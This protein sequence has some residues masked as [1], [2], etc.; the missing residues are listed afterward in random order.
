[1]GWDRVNR[2]V[3]LGRRGRLMQAGVAD[4]ALMPAMA[5]PVLGSRRVRP[6]PP[7]SCAQLVDPLVPPPLSAFAGRQLANNSTR[8]QILLNH[9]NNININ[10]NSFIVNNNNN[11]KKKFNTNLISDR[12]LMTDSYGSHSASNEFLNWSVSTVVRIDSFLSY[13]VTVFSLILQVMPEFIRNNIL[14]VLSFGFRLD[15]F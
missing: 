14:F 1:M 15:K 4:Q 9:N 11:L 13:I 2:S 10:N 6:Q 5:S 12:N 3:P 7:Q 8:T